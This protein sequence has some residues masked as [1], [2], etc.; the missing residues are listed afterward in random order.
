MQVL[1]RSSN[2]FPQA[3]K[4]PSISRVF[5]HQ[6]NTSVGKLVDGTSELNRMAEMV[7]IS[8]LSDSTEIQPKSMI[9]ENIRLEMLCLDMT[10]CSFLKEENCSQNMMLK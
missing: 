8:F 1:P 7:T 2:S 5:L 4:I 10:H 9:Q 3:R 6:M